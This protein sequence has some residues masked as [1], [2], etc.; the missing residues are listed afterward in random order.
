L[1][2]GILGETRKQGKEVVFGYDNLVRFIAARVLL[3]DGWPLTKIR[4]HFDVSSFA[5]IEALFPGG[6]P[7]QAA[8]DHGAMERRFY[9]DDE[10]QIAQSPMPSHSAMSAI[11]KIRERT[12]RGKATEPNLRPARLLSVGD[13]AAQMTGMKSELQDALRRLGLPPGGPATEEMTLIA[14]ATWCQLLVQ[15]DR[16]ARLTMEEAEEIGRAVTASLLHLKRK[17]DR[18]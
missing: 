8:P 2:R 6:Q 11:R 17:K 7:P 16:L 9:A 1:Q 18:E 13:R 5:E 10:D 15:T 14:I 4:E 3:N 12:G